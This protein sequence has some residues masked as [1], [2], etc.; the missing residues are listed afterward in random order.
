MEFSLLGFKAFDIGLLIACTFGA[1][2]GSIVQAILATI[3]HDGPPKNRDELKIAPPDLQV[4]RGLWISMRLFVGGVLGFVFGLY[5]IGML[6]ESPATFARIWALSFVVG[7]AA[8][9]IWSLK[10]DRLVRQLKAEDVS[11]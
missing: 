10:S 1:V 3:D 2:F 9:K 11:S 7:Y 8:P 4:T 5:F 6:N